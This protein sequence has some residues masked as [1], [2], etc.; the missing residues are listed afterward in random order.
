MIFFHAP[1]HNKRQCGKLFLRG[2]KMLSEGDKSPVVLT[3]TSDEF[4]QMES[5][6]LDDDASEA[7]SLVKKFVKRLKEQKNRGLKSHLA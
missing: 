4:Q 6:A 2:I 1:G 7:L 3:I 5:A